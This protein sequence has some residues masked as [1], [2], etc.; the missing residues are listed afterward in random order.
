MPPVRTVS[1][2]MVTLAES[3]IK[4]R[5]IEES[6]ATS[7]IKILMNLNN[8]KPFNNLSFLKYKDAVM[9]KLSTYSESTQKSTLGT[10][11]AVLTSLKDKATYKSLYNFYYERMSDASKEA[12]S[13]DTT[14]KTKTQKMNWV[15]WD[16]IIKKRAEMEKNLPTSKTKLLTVES[17]NNL[18][19]YVILSLYT[20]IPPRRNLDYQNLFVVKKWDDKMD[21][22]KNYYDLATDKLIF[23]KYKTSKAHGQQEIDISN[24][25]ELLKALT[26]FIHFHPDK[27]KPEYR[28]LVSINGAPLT[29]INSIT[30]ILNK[31]F[32]KNVGSTMIRHVYLSDKYKLD[33]D[34]MK[35]DAD[36]MGHTLSTQ[37]DYIKTD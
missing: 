34:E 35:K 13:A 17:Y 26:I 8:G 23:N 37:R 31:V 11:V 16:D 7:Y 32:E 28:L 1:P 15:E 10:I 5:D 18:L 22:S 2:F 3:L 9:A 19:S 24:N 4:E 21:K 33:M 14:E 20:M 12:R 27:K 30:R 6:T 36:A 25:E 29:S